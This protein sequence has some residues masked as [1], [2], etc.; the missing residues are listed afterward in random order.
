MVAVA[1]IVRE[2]LRAWSFTGIFLLWRLYMEVTILP[3]M[4]LPGKTA[5]GG[6]CSGNV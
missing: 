4:P 5:S 1:I 6:I 3:R 2:R